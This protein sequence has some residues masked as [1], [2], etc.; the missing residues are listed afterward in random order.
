MENKFKES[1]FIEQIIVIGENQKHPSALIVPSYEFLKG[2]CEL[3]EI[4]V[5]ILSNEQI[6]TQ[7]RVNARLLKEVNLINQQF[8]QW[9]QIKNPKF[10]TEDFTI[11]GGEL[12]PT[13]KLKRKNILSKY[14]D[15]V[16]EIYG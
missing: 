10:L 6:V 11:E 1:R 4:D 7:P 16:E 9:E 13:L 2:W 12:T 5:K 14:A 8:G 15:L 3:K